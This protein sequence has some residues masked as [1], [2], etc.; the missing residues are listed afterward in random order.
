[1]KHTRILALSVMVLSLS[2]WGCQPVEQTRRQDVTNLY[3][4]G[5]Y[6]E[7]IPAAQ[8]NLAEAEKAKGR[9]SLE[10]ASHL[11][12]LGLL[13]YSVGDFNQAEP[14]LRRALGIRERHLGDSH[15]DTAV[16]LNNLALVYEAMGKYSQAEP[17]YRRALAIR[18]NKL[19]PDHPDVAASYNN[20]AAL[21]YA[22]GDYG[23]AIPMLQKAQKI[24]ERALGT[25]HPDVAAGLS[26]LAGMYVALG[27]YDQAEPLYK[28]AIRI[29]EDKLG[30]GHPDVAAG[31]NNLALLYQ[32]QGRY[33]EA[34]PLYEKALN[35]MEHELGGGHPDLAAAYNNLALLHQDQ[36]DL[37][38]AESLNRKALAI[39][40]NSL[41]PDHPDTASTLDNL[42]GLYAAKGEYAKAHEHFKRA[43]ALDAKLIE[44]VIGFTSEEKKVQFLATKQ[45]SLEAFLCLTAAHLKDDP[46]ARLDAFNVWLTRKGMILEAQRQFQEAALNSE[47]ASTRET[48]R[49][50]SQVRAHL[51]RLTF[52]GPG[53]ESMRTW[54]KRIEE[55]KKNK[56]RL[57]ADLARDS[58]TFALQQQVARADALAVAQALPQ[59]SVLVDFARINIYDFQAGRGRNRWSGAKYLAFVMPAGQTAD[60][61]MVDLGDAER[62]DQAVTAL[63]KAVANLRDKEGT[64]TDEAARALYSMAFAPLEPALAGAGR[65]F[66]SP[67]GNLSLIP[68][69]ILIAGDGR[70]LVEK[71]LFNYLGAG[72]DVPA[73]G[74]GGGRGGSPV[75]I[76]DPD[77]NLT[78]TAKRQTLTELGLPGDDRLAAMRSADM[79][80]LSFGRLP[81]TR[82]EVQAISG[83]LG[84]ADVY[85]GE[86]AIEEVLLGLDG[87]RILHLATHG[88]FLSDTQ[89]MKLTNRET[90]DKKPIFVNPLVRSGLALAGANH[91]LS[92]GGSTSDGVFT[93][94]KVLALRL[95]G[96]GLVVLSA[97]ETGLGEIK[98][99]EGVYGLRRAFIQAGAQG[100]VMSM[101]SVPDRETKELMIEFYRNLTDNGDDRAEALRQAALKQ[102]ETVRARYGRPNPFFWGAFV[103]LGQP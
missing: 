26:N 78:A 83:I 96:T 24:W 55:L 45:S 16:T 64:Q 77:F 12:L 7:A 101:W 76:G 69:E 23:Q 8:Q 68:F 86:R 89:F 50:L 94:E 61:R 100:L 39:L 80:G 29:R 32:D 11:N 47:D 36:G 17:Y 79:P 90:S 37:G 58:Q 42:A 2:A 60:F 3:G 22:L 9:D 92:G 102:I 87:P 97:C 52:A 70:F 51:S 57:E 91:A 56:D 21:Y 13:Y 5:R 10:A 44:Q 30:T 103:Y 38:K 62:I 34:V 72:R 67:D 93:A 40:E 95:K 41:G 35:I 20:M 54:R 84:R 33:A 71:Y 43:Q 49:E 73:L 75:L 4:Q 1:M 19:G 6:A 63:K 85:V 18:E 27:K 14:A 59:G 31:Y 81:G 46:A 66:L 25:D 28:R 48:F 99:G 53:S 65:I 74:K 15:L 82:E 98:S 88:F